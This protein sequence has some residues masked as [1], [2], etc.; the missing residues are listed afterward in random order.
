[1]RFSVVLKKIWPGTGR[2]LVLNFLVASPIVPR[3]AR[4][5]LLRAIGMDIERSIISS[6][7]WFGSRR[8]SIGTGTFV[9]YGC[10]FNTSARIKIGRNCDIG[11]DVLFVTST[12]DIGRTNRRAG[13]PIA[14]SIS[15]GNGVWIG[16]RSVLLPGV[17][18]GD[19]SIVA[20]GAVVT[21]NVP[22]NTVVA[23][24]PARPMRNL[25]DA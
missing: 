10:R 22:A 15:I 9:N 6:G 17:V 24:V 12:H 1:M 13:R 8:V 19:G 3:P 4:W 23:G 11:M 25:D 18:I 2:D 20:A 5:L 21:A 16:A 14:K 7:V